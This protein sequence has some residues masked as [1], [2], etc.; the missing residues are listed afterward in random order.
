MDPYQYSTAETVHLTANGAS[1]LHR[2]RRA[3]LP[4]Q[5]SRRHDRIWTWN[6]ML[7]RYMFI[8]LSIP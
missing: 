4:V 3:G 7:A 2:T 5:G 1:D 6:F 8:C